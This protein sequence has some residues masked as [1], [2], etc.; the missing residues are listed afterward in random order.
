LGK[1]NFIVGPSGCGKTTLISI[2]AGILNQDSG[3]VKLLDKDQ[4]DLTEKAKSSFRKENIGFIFQQFNLVPTISVIENVAIPLLIQGKG[5]SEALK[6]ASEILNKVGL[7]DKE[8]SLPKNL[9][10][11]Q[12]QRVAIARALINK[13]KIIICDEPIASLDGQTGTTVMELLSSITKETATTVI[14]VTHDN[15]IYNYADRIIEMED[16]RIKN[17]REING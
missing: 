3:K 6:R 9:S 14:I 12:Q 13:P 16:G 5:F 8:K 1:I 4:K 11:D 17:V 2:I 7:K 15:R 10:G